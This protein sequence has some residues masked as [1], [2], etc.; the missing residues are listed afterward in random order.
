MAPASPPSLRPWSYM[1]ALTY[2]N[3]NLLGYI[4][5]SMLKEKY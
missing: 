5:I 2:I 1:H 3:F 4:Y